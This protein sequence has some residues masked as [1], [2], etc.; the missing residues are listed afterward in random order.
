MSF[1]HPFSLGQ[2]NMKHHPETN[3][4]QYKILLK[5]QLLSY[6]IFFISLHG[7]RVNVRKGK[8]G[9]LLYFSFLSPNRTRNRFDESIFKNNKNIFKQKYLLV[10]DDNVVLAF[11]NQ[12]LEFDVGRIERLFYQS[13][14]FFRQIDWSNFKMMSLPET[15]RASY[16]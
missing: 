13:V 16:P 5:H 6:M 15:S 12:K 2:R 10:G 11:A 1:Q 8:S 9:C 14:S 7:N 3:N 4:H